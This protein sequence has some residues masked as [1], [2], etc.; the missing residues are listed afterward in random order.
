MDRDLSVPELLS[1]S[2]L[3]PDALGVGSR[4]RSSTHTHRRDA[5]S[6]P[7]TTRDALEALGLGGRASGHM[8]WRE[9]GSPMWHA[10]VALDR[11]GEWG[12]KAGERALPERDMDLAGGEYAT[13]TRFAHLLDG[14]REQ[15]IAR[16]ERE[17]G[18]RER[19]TGARRD[20]GRR[21]SGDAATGTMY[22]AYHASDEELEGEGVAVT[23]FESRDLFTSSTPSERPLTNVG[24]RSQSAWARWGGEPDGELPVTPPSRML[25]SRPANRGL[26]DHLSTQ[27]E[28]WQWFGDEMADRKVD[29]ELRNLLLSTRMAPLS[30][31]ML[32]TTVKDMQKSIQQVCPVVA[33]NIEYNVPV[34][35]YNVPVVAQNICS[36]SA[37]SKQMPG[38]DQTKIDQIQLLISRLQVRH[39]FFLGPCMSAFTY[40][41]CELTC[42]LAH[43]RKT[44]YMV[45]AT[46]TASFQRALRQAETK[47][48]KGSRE[49]A[50]G[51]GCLMV[52]A[53]VTVLQWST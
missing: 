15:E 20:Q 6:P 11:D 38:D 32:D 21:M 3:S 16:L 19:G 31:Q 24:H 45:F 39:C 47:R 35:E 48:R 22:G 52:R 5:G 36:P 29:E 41:V 12:G 27:E 40:L 28:H 26:E 1:R 46:A 23:D 25:T 37:G 14:E 44:P 2:P 50:S 8:S 7:L 33:Q 4:P 30:D 51:G 34:V 42:L 13:D 49:R 18:L 43:R 17:L 53:R 10:M 9:A